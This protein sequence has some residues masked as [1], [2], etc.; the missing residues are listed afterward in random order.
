MANVIY[1]LPHFLLLSKITRNITDRMKP[2]DRKG[3]K[4]SDPPPVSILA[5]S[6]NARA[7]EAPRLTWR[8]WKVMAVWVRWGRSACKMF[9]EA[10][11]ARLIQK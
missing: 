11:N 3:A 6:M 7:M 5:K 8:R 4:T 9:K 10:A 2:A 1:I